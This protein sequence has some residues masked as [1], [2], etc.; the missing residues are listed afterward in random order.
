MASH[1]GRNGIMTTHVDN[2][3]ITAGTLGRDVFTSG[4][5]A[6]ICGVAPRTVSKWFDTGQLRGYRIPGSQDRRITRR[7]LN[8][9]FRANSLPFRIGGETAM[10]VG[11]SVPP[12]GWPAATVCVP[13]AFAA[14]QAC[15]EDL[16]SLVVIDAGAVGRY[17]ATQV[18]RHIRGL[19]RYATTAVL[20]VLAEDDGDGMALDGVEGLRGEAGLR[21]AADR[22]A[23]VMREGV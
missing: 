18:A 5:V 22:A 9:F 8:E 3:N 17:T 12:R 19:P 7:Q 23:V 20:V 1:N 14:G 21:T 11:H 10:L 13:H 2:V 15:A 6:R 16:P 4:M